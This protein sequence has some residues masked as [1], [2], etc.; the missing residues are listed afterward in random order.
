MGT[1]NG[2]RQQRRVACVYHFYAHYREAVLE[3]LTR[4]S[5]HDWTFFGSPASVVPSIKKWTPSAEVKFRA[6]RTYCFGP[7]LFQ[8]GLLKI[9]LSREFQDL[10]L[11]GNS[12][13]PTTWI[14]AILGR[15]SG[16]RVYFWTH[17]WI[18]KES[19]LKGAFRKTFYGN[20]S[21]TF[22]GKGFPEKRKT[23]SGRHV[24]EHVSETRFLERVFWSFQ[25]R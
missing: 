24:P 19:G 4:S 8:F 12:S 18:H 17:G 15:L 13:W 1:A 14:A 11:L 9:A 2:N 22:S 5:Q 6:L 7:L 3:E 23:I 20:V 10:V 25:G 16:K 21:Q